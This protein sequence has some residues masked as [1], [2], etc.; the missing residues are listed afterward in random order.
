MRIQANIRR[1][2]RSPV[3]SH[4]LRLH[5][6]SCPLLHCK[7][8]ERRPWGRN[9][10]EGGSFSWQERVQMVA[11]VIRLKMKGSYRD[12]SRG[13]Q[14]SGYILPGAGKKCST[15]NGVLKC[16][17][18]QEGLCRKLN[19]TVHAADEAADVPR[20]ESQCDRHNFHG[21]PEPSRICQRLALFPYVE[22]TGEPYHCA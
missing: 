1:M 14:D 16:P 2:N 9:G 8:R 21:Q 5:D 12:I 7:A 20:Q 17:Q 10:I 6:A 13:L 22:E 15:E 4:E 19:R 3:L 18:I 11:L